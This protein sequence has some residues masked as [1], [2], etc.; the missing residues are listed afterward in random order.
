VNKDDMYRKLYNDIQAI[1]LEWAQALDDLADQLRALDD[2]RRQKAEATEALEL[3]EQAVIMGEMHKTGRVN[4][5]N[6]EKRKMQIRLLLAD[7]REEDPNCKAF[8]ETGEQADL[9]VGELEYSIEML[10]QK[11]SYLR[12]QARMVSGL[13]YALAG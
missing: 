10:R 1:R 6:A 13:A 4:G 11:I 7:L 12:N 8:A 2:A 5:S 9:R 3:Y